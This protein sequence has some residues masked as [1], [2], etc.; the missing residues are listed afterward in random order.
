[1]PLVEESRTDVC[2]RLRRDGNK[3]GVRQVISECVFDGRF[4]KLLCVASRKVSSI[5]NIIGC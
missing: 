5:D 2:R 4:D 3:D 1:M